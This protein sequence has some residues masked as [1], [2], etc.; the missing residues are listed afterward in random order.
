MDGPTETELISME[1]VLAEM[2]QWGGR[3]GD[4]ESKPV[5]SC[6][7]RFRGAVGCLVHNTPLTFN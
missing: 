2:S 5:D 4:R 7:D 3:K 1:H 6:G